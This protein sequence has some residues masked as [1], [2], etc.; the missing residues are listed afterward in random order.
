MP[1]DATP[2]AEA[3]EGERWLQQLRKGSTKLAILQLLSEADRYGYELV[4]ETRA[5]T[6]GALAVAEGNLYPAL[7]ALEADGFVTSYWREVEPGVPPRKYY[8]PTEKGV[9]L[10]KRMV[11]GWRDHAA[12]IRRLLRDGGT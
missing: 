10:H 7:H 4:S 11:E 3:H 9:E 1:R 2:A 6:R 5:R 8:R 12:A